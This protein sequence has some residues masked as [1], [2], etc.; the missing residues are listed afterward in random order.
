MPEFGYMIIKGQQV[1]DDPQARQK[2][3]VKKPDDFRGFEKHTKPLRAKSNPQLGYYWG[4]LVSE[5]SKELIKL[6]WTVTVGKGKSSFERRWDHGGD[7]KRY[8]DTHDWLKENAAK[9]GDQGEY[10]TLSEQDLDECRKFI[11]NVIWICE[12]WLSM[13]KEELEAKRPKIEVKKGA[14]K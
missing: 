6:G 11:D 2:F 12:H 9:I 4:L 7:D 8:T 5:V 3:L 1:Y 14:K 10:V 13:N